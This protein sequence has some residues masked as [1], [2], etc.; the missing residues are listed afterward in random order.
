MSREESFTPVGDLWYPFVQQQQWRDA[1]KEDDS[2][3]QENETPRRNAQFRR[4]ELV[5]W[6][7]STN[8][9]ETAAIEQEVNYRREDLFF[10]LVVE[11][12]IPV[13]GSTC[14]KINSKDTPVW[15]VIPAANAPR[16]SSLPMVLQIPIVRSAKARY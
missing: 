12:A 13:D 1:T 8:I 2:N 10:G 14:D 11:T 16:R 7:P 15:M 5:E 9:D 3:E 4:V 6:Q